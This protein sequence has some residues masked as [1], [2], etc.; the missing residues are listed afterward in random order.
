[1]LDAR[2]ARNLRRT[3]GLT[4]QPNANPPWKRLILR[5][6]RC[7]PEDGCCALVLAT[8]CS[9]ILCLTT[10]SL[11]ACSDSSDAAVSMRRVVVHL[12]SQHLPVSASLQLWWTGWGGGG[13]GGGGL[14]ATEQ[15]KCRR[16]RQ[17][18]MQIPNFYHPANTAWYS[19]TAGMR[20]KHCFVCVR[21]CRGRTVI[22]QSWPAPRPRS[23]RTPGPGTRTAQS[24]CG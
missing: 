4:P 17:A 5:W 22:P 20:D 7:C 3:V 13:G 19:R 24:P 9:V 12:L 10:C 2:G 23:G 1:M 21:Q 14:A 15:M 16:L 11:W 6:Q 18:S 8:L